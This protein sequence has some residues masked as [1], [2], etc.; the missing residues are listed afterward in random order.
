MTF[1][2]G[3]HAPLDISLAAPFPPDF[4]WGTATS[5]YQIEGAVA[6]DGRK[7]SIWDQFAAT[8]GKVVGG[9]TGEIAV[10]H[11]HRMPADVALMASLNIRAYRFSV[12]WPRVI[13]E[14][15]GA[16]NARGLDFYDRLVDELLAHDIT[17]LLTLY[18]WDLPLALHERGG[19][20]NRDTA[21]AF[22]DYA[23]VVARRLGDRVDWW[24]TQ[25]EPWCA[26]FLGYG[27]GIHAPGVKDMP[28][29]FT[30][31][32]HLLLSHGLALPRL[33]AATR[34]GAQMGLSL[35]LNPVYTADDRPETQRIAEEVDLFNNRW[36]LDPIFRGKYPDALFAQFDAPPPPIQDG[37][38]A[39]ISAPIDYLGINY[40]SRSMVPIHMGTNPVGNGSAS[41]I[42]SEHDE[43]YTAMGWEIYPPGLYDLLKTLQ[44][45]YQPPPIII[46]ENGAAF[47]DQVD[48]AGQVHDPR[49]V[50]YVRAHV[51]AMA[52]VIADGLPLKGYFLWSFTDNFEWAEGYAKR[53]GIVYVDFPT[54]QRIVKSSGQWYADFVGAQGKGSA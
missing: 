39:L 52:R 19:W 1:P 18:H 23:E 29:A 17:P 37:D 3:Q 30:A 6:E 47:T 9:D 44:R 54:Q 49:R 16:V 10:D 22:A 20:L 51:Q 14:G 13:P 5:S 32:H 7:P 40:Y 27:S 43:A 31:G 25:N 4:L 8:P 26:A 15:V 53:F 34:P 12:A 42:S 45:D 50:D 33:R 41:V 35:N 11:Y 28:S 24:L 36:F 48:V 2:T 38:M 21:Y 46:T